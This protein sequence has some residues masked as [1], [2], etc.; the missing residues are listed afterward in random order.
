MARGCHL[1]YSGHTGYAGPISWNPCSVL[2]GIG[3]GTAKV[4]KDK[5]RS[6]GGSVNYTNLGPYFSLVKQTP[7]FTHKPE[8]LGTEGFFRQ[9][10]GKNGLLKFYGYF[11]AGRVGFNTESPE[12]DT[13]VFDIKNANV[14]TNLSWIGFLAE[15]LET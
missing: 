2:C 1:P 14:Y 15:H 5:G 9:K 10:T 11:N 7:D 6:I 12:G 13:L 4:W 3:L 8:F